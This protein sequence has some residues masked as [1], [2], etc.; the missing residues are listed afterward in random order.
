MQGYITVLSANPSVT[1]LRAMRVMH[2]DSR[3]H[4]TASHTIPDCTQNIQADNC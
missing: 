4:L 1:N 3:F 2:G